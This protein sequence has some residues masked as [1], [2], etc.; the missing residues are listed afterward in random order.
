MIAPDLST[1]IEAATANY[2]R[3]VLLVGVPAS[4]KSLR[5]RDFASAHGYPYV[6]LSGPTA[7]RLLEFSER[8]RRQRVGQIIGDLVEAAGGAVTLLDDIELLFQPALATDPLRLLQMLSRNRTLVATWP[9]MFADDLLWYADVGHL[10]YCSYCAPEAV[11]V[12]M[13]VMPNLASPT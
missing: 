3:L 6:S 7:A 2:F 4:G 10:E 8:Q 9:G 12:T 5:M 1:A 11:I 13:G